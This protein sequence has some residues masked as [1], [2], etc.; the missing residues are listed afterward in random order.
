MKIDDYLIEEKQRMEEIGKLIREGS[1]LE[2]N[3]K[4][5]ELKAWQTKLFGFALGE[6]ITIGGLLK[7]VR[8]AV[9]GEI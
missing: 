2:A 7:I 3:R 9:K 4:Q 1:Q 5:E 8:I 6:A